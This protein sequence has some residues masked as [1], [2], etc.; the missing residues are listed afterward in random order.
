[1]VKNSII[2]YI[3]YRGAKI[4]YIQAYSGMNIRLIDS[5][6]FLPM[7]IAKLPS[8]FGFKELKKKRFFPHHFNIPENQDYTGTFPAIHFYRL[9]MSCNEKKVLEEWHQQQ[10]GKVFNF[11]TEIV[12]Y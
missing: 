9:E 11:K 6:N 10:D 2:A 12:D 4:M 3:I 5:L 1:M 7:R 8:A